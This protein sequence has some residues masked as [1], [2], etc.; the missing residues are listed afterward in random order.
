MK[1]VDVQGKEQSN[2]ISM[3]NSGIGNCMSCTFM[4]Y[5]LLY[6]PMMSIISEERLFINV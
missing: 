3:E 2:R 1:A 4:L 5:M 6:M